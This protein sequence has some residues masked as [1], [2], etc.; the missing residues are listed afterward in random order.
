MKTYVEFKPDPKGRSRQ[1]AALIKG[2]MR[3][4]AEDAQRKVSATGTGL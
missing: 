2:L 4:T 3:P 1:N